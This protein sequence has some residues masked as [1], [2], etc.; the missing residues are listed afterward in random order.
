M[1]REMGKTHSFQNYI[2]SWETIKLV[3]YVMLMSR[4]RIC[5]NNSVQTC[6]HYVLP[7]VWAS[8]YIT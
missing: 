2:E 4:D 8:S 5:S 6:E 3:L 1:E 7:W